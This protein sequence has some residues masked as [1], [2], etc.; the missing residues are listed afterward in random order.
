MA[1]L[2]LVPVVGAVAVKVWRQDGKSKYAHFAESSRSFFIGIVH[3]RRDR[4]TQI[5]GSVV[6][7]MG[8]NGSPR[9]SE[10]EVELDETDISPQETVELEE[11]FGFLR[12]DQG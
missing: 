4:L 10:L 11:G 2:A 1:K 9:D 3:D 5:T 7:G 8:I 12:G 6:S